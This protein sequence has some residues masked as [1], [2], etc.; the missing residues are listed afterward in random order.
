[1]QRADLP[2]AANLKHGPQA[3][4]A[5]GM[6]ASAPNSA[7]RN[8]TTLESHE[9]FLQRSRRSRFHRSRSSSTYLIRTLDSPAV[10]TSTDEGIGQI[11]IRLR[12]F[13]YPLLRITQR[14]TLSELM[15]LDPEALVALIVAQQEQFTAP[16]STST[17]T[18]LI[19]CR[20]GLLRLLPRTR[21]GITSM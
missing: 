6:K 4:K 18:A 9:H 17:V 8:H 12:R 3:H 5:G 2:L 15:K 10:P 21:F 20:A 19:K 14:A 11:L 16:K 1:M 13:R 7:G